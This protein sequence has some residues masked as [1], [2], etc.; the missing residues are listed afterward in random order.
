MYKIYWAFLIQTTWICEKTIANITKQNESTWKMT[1][2]F[3]DTWLIIQNTVHF[4]VSMYG[5]FISYVH[6]F[7]LILTLFSTYTSVTPLPLFCVCVLNEP[8]CISPLFKYFMLYNVSQDSWKRKCL[9]VPVCVSFQFPCLKCT[10]KNSYIMQYIYIYNICSD[11][12]HVLEFL[13]YGLFSERICQTYIISEFYLYF[14][15]KVILPVIL[16]V[17]LLVI[18]VIYSA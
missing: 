9:F 4:H 3:T 6:M 2:S 12:K 10:L 18:L 14:Y 13:W 5:L 8:F 7:Y 17:I 1:I 15:T 16:L 11:D